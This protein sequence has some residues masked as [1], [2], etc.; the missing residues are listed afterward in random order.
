MA[1]LKLKTKLFLTYIAAGVIP[2][3]LVSLWSYKNDNDSIE[4]TVKATVTQY[5]RIVTQ[6]I[7]LREDYVRG[8]GRLAAATIEVFDG[9]EA[10]DTEAMNKLAKDFMA[11][12]PLLTFVVMAKPDGTVVAR[13]HSDQVG[14]SI[15][16]QETFRIAAGG[17]ETLAIESGTVAKLTVR[18]AFPVVR[19]G[20]QAGVISLGF[21]LAS[22]DFV[23]QLKTMLGAEC[24]VFA[25]D[26]RAATTIINNGQRAVGTKMTNPE[27]LEK[28]LRAGQFFQDKNN[29]L[30]QSYDTA[31][32]PI[33]DIKNEIV[34][35]FFI[36]IPASSYEAQQRMAI[37]VNLSAVGLTIVVMFLVGWLIARSISGPI[38]R[39]V[40][41]LAASI[42]QVSDAAHQIDSACQKLAESSSSQSSSLVESSSALEELAAQSKNNAANS[43]KASQVM[44]DTYKSAQDAS[45]SMTE[46]TET[47]T[48]IRTSSD[49]VA[50][51][52]KTIE[53][54][55]FQTNLLAL[56]A[57]VEAARAGEHGMGFA[58]VA[59]EVRNLAQRAAEAAGNTDRLIS[60][61]VAFSRK[62]EAVAIKVSESIGLTL[63]STNEVSNLV[64][65]VEEASNEQS[66][67][68]GQI[69]EAVTIMD[70]A[71]QD[72]SSTSQTTAAISHELSQQS[73]V[74]EEIMLELARLVDARRAGELSGRS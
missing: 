27:V 29:I 74:L 6:E 61:S 4:E 31:Y 19:D 10:G 57:S 13:G 23:D 52:I 70:G 15:G 26:T 41:R 7:S 45:N 40:E 34:G 33:R 21:T 17:R 18:G 44:G 64:R 63:K 71:G 59:E 67:G 66:I 53:D 14:D 46:M 9:L 68:I 2:V 3:L 55:S 54:I 48:S 16:N 32:W 38:N 42:H 28:V 5:Q 58:V 22:N 20:R 72:I 49:Q 47:M 12:T 60:E 69:N 24:T 37:I 36:G 65:V 51:I 30:G 39:A 11:K 43:V 73:E 1:L 8:V 62:G 25:D 56:N 35:M 50:G